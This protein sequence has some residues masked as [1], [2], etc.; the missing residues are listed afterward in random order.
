MYVQGHSLYKHLWKDRGRGWEGSTG[1]GAAAKHEDLNP[2]AHP[3]GENSTQTTHSHTYMYVSRCV[4]ICA[5]LSTFIY[6]HICVCEWKMRMVGLSVCLVITTVIQRRAVQFSALSR[7]LMKSSWYLMRTTNGC[8]LQ[9]CSYCYGEV[10]T[11]DYHST[12]S[13]AS[14]NVQIKAI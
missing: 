7:Y 12:P 8:G 5:Y 14:C 3:R 2:G 6:V 9:S 11:G 13:L 1:K 10:A 4:C